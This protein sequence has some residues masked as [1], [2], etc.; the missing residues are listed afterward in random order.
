MFLE[1]AIQL[2]GIDGMVTGDGEDAFLDIEGLADQGRDFLV[3]RCGAQDYEV[4]K[5]PESPSTK[6]LTAVRGSTAAS[7]LGTR[8]TTCLG[9]SSR[10]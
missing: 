5:N 3:A 10:W 4:I 7:A 6:D 8:T 9:P 2:D 1:Y